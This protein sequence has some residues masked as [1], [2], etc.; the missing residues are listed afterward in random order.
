MRP[1]DYENFPHDERIEHWV[2]VLYRGM[3]W[4][5]EDGLDEMEVF[6]PELLARLTSD[7]PAI[8]GLLSAVLARLALMHLEDPHR[9]ITDANRRM[10]THATHDMDVAE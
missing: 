8:G 7:D 3:R 10:G 2:A 1:H 4:C 5:G 6:T 9:F